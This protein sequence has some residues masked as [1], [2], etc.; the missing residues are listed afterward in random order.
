MDPDNVGEAPRCEGCG[1][2][3]GM[4]PWLPPHH[5][6]LELWT[7]E[8]GDVAFGP[9]DELVV[10]EQFVALFKERELTGLSGFHPVT[11]T[12]VIQREGKK[13]AEDPPTYFC[14][15]VA[16]GRA[17]IDG[18][19]SGLEFVRPWT[20]AECREGY[21]L[22]AKRII[23]K[24]ET[25]SGEDIFFP[26]GL[27]QYMVTERFKDSFEEHQINNGVLI[28][29]SEYSFDLEPWREDGVLGPE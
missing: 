24:P 6:E 8:F 23:L 3:V 1:G 27:A 11:I 16:R 29:A 2:F 28:D 19:A 26:R 15:S 14:V 20:C 21:V 25:W 13:P 17:I 22:R 4:F 9:G 5:A 10:S 7:S 18:N 12:R